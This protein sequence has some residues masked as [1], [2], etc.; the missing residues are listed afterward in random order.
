MEGEEADEGTWDDQ[1][2][3]NSKIYIEYGTYELI[4]GTTVNVSDAYSQA[5]QE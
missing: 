2:L 5:V 1:S 3:P 4:L